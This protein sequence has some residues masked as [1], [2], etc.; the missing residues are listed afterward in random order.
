MDELQARSPVSCDVLGKIEWGGHGGNMNWVGRGKHVPILFL[1]SGFVLVSP[2]RFAIL[3][4]QNGGSAEEGAHIWVPD[5]HW[6]S[7]PN[8]SLVG[9]SV[10][11]ALPLVLAS[12]Q[13]GSN[14]GSTE[15]SQGLLLG[16]LWAAVGCF[17]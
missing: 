2:S 8:P 7:N 17:L 15:Q 4:A 9:R 3:Q 16:W 5:S 13:R 12:E 1:Q 11:L 6:L 10:Q 14:W